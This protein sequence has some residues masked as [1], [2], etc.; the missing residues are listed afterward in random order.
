ML[1]VCQNGTINIPLFVRMELSGFN[2]HF[3]LHN[4]ICQCLIHV[5]QIVSV[6]LKM[7]VQ[8]ST[9]IYF[10]HFKLLNMIT[11]LELS[12]TDGVSLSLVSLWPWRSAVMQSH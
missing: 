11:Y 8:K 7:T 10:K 1:L 9:P 4:F 2:L 12:I 6:N 3:T 5:D